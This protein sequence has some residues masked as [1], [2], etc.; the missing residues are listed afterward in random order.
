VVIVRL[1]G[2]LDP[3][4]N[5]T[6]QIKQGK[7]LDGSNKSHYGMN[8]NDLRSAEKWNPCNIRGLAILWNRASGAA[9]AS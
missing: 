6:D 7:M 3:T 5:L 4:D 8:I 1:R 2:A 9:T